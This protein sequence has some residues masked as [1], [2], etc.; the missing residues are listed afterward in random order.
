[1]VSPAII[2]ALL[3]SLTA[4][5]TGTRGLLGLGVT[6]AILSLM[7]LFFFRD[8]ERHP[9]ADPRAVVSPADGRVIV[10][11]TLPDG[12]KHIAVFLSI[13]DVHVNRTP[14]AGEATKIII[15]PGAFFHAGSLRAAGENARVDVE[16]ISSFGPV[17]WRQVSGAIARKISCRLKTR[18]TFQTGDRFGLIYFG[19]RMDIFLP[20]SA[21]LAIT[22]D[23]RVLAGESVIATF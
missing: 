10:A 2:I 14:I 7:A 20:P 19:S 5:L 9:P 12:R 15:T 13:F 11:G 1:M 4:L 18:D 3:L 8:P 17:A 6:V 22:K 21:A 23:D 16:A